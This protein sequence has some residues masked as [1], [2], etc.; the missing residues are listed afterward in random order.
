MNYQKY[1]IIFLT[2]DH[3]L[4]HFKVETS[5]TFVTAN[6]RITFCRY[7][8][9]VSQSVTAIKYFEILAMLLRKF[10]YNFAIQYRIC[11]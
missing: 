9:I 5:P 1:G 2:H 11:Q 3:Q 8:A 7:D 10:C 6:K 4:I